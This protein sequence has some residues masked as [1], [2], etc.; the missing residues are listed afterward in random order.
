MIFNTK[1]CMGCKICELACSFHHKGVFN[2]DMASI[3]IVDD[4]RKNIKIKIYKK[5]DKNH[6]QCDYCYMCVEYCPM[7]A[8]GEL[9]NILELAGKLKVAK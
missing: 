2:P 4:I 5:K 6:L 7:Y 3:E 8:K 9:K 1:Y